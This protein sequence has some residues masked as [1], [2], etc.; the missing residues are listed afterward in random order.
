MQDQQLLGEYRRTRSQQAFGELVGRYADVVY[1]AARRQVKAPAMAEDVA[2]AVFLLLSQKAGRIGRG[3]LLAGWLLRATWFTSRRT[4]TAER[5]REYHERRA[6]AM[7]TEA[8]EP[9]WDTYSEEIDA[10]M[11]K[12]GAAERSAV[13]LRYFCGLSLREVGEQMS[14]S[15]DAA[16][17]RVDRGL[18]KLR[19]L[20]S[21]KVMVPSAAGL[22]VAMAAN[23][24]EAA[25]ASVLAIATGQASASVVTLAKGVGKMLAWAKVRVAAVMCLGILAAGGMAL[26]VGQIP[27]KPALAPAPSTVPSPS[28]VAKGPAST[29]KGTVIAAYQAALAGDLEAHLRCF[30]YPSD[31]QTRILRQ[32]VRASAAAGTLMDATAEKF[33]KEYRTALLG[34]MGMGVEPADV[35]RAGETITGTTAEVDMGAAG[36]GIIPLVKVG[37]VWLIKPQ[38]LDRLNA[39]SIATTERYVPQIQKLADAIRQGKFQTLDQAKL[40]MAKAMGMNPAP[41]PPQAGQPTPLEN[42]TKVYGLKGGIH[43]TPVTP[44]GSV[45]RYGRSK[46]AGRRAGLPPHLQRV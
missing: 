20:L 35:D 25:P 33:G 41:M 44:R 2:Q 7:R 46:T 5:R 9:A 22:A 32:V 1:A 28:A 31:Q 29:P 16:R 14:L 3:E 24:S 27:T 40:A 15:E 34:P 17:K 23:G 8:T 38:I 19:T 21:K 42:L 10:A 26:V 43:L 6:A 4:L 36:P 12:L 30:D 13:T 37:D 45:W 11:A 18:E 39:D